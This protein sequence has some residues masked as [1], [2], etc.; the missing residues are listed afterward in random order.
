MEIWRQ[1]GQPCYYEVV[2]VQYLDT[3]FN[4]TPYVFASGDVKIGKDVNTSVNVSS[5]PV[6]IDRGRYGGTLT[7]NE[8]SCSGAMLTFMDVSTT[9]YKR[10][11]DNALRLITWGSSSGQFAFNPQIY[12][13]QATATD[14]YFS[15]IQLDKDSANSK[16]EWTAS[17]FKN[18]VPVTGVLTSPTLQVVKRSDGSSLIP[19]TGMTAV[20]TLG[21]VV[22]YD[23]SLTANRTTLGESYIAVVNATIDGS[24]QTFRKVV[25]RDL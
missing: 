17:W 3:S 14:I 11:E 25:G 22:K 1:Y 7:S 21:G 18:S 4:T 15:D 5:L 2:M 20:G 8:V 6:H 23:E 12:P 19:A 10:I 16:D 9:G 24:A 13:V